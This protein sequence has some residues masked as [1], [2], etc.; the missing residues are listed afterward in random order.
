M[1]SNPSKIIDPYLQIA[2][3][4]TRYSVV[5]KF[6]RAIDGVQTSA[7]D[8]WER[9]DSAATQ[10]IWTAPTTARTHA[11][12]SSSANDD[13][14]PAGTGARTL[15][16]YGLTSW[17][18]AETSEDITLNGVGSVNTSNSYVIIHRMQVLTKG[19]SG[20]NVGTITATAAVDGT[21][22]AT[23][24]PGA[25]QTQMAI[26]GIPSVKTAYM[27]GY[28]TALQESA[29]AAALTVDLRL[30]VNPNPD[31]ELLS[32]LIKHTLGLTSTGTTYFRHDF[33]PYFKITG[34]AIIKL[35]GIASAADTDVSGGFDLILA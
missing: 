34:P 10:S 13:G 8:L 32:F 14:D 2:E 17:T 12:V 20:P 7:T 1:I 5:N 19:A 26:Y 25:G 31:A 29:A 11:I 16:I 24:L 15:R 35:D 30:L 21:I 6:G 27:T 4:S 9:A 3:G 22:T 18:T 28:Y 33:K 23:I